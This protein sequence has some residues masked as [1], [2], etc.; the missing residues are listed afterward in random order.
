MLQGDKSHQAAV[1]KNSIAEARISRASAFGDA[2]FARLSLRTDSLSDEQRDS[3]Y[4]SRS[5]EG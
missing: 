4:M 2:T 5:G 1:T 3:I